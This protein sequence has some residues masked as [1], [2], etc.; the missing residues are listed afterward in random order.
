MEGTWRDLK[1]EKLRKLWKCHFLQRN[2]LIVNKMEGH[3]IYPWSYRGI[4]LWQD[5]FVRDRRKNKGTEIFWIWTSAINSCL[6]MLHILNQIPFESE[7]SFT[8]GKTANVKRKCKK[9]HL[10]I[11]TN[12]LV[13]GKQ[14]F[15]TWKNIFRFIQIIERT[16]LSESV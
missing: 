8:K 9:S 13:F 14:K 7:I 16:I 15:D 12:T 11:Y 1:V 5:T 2:I 10:H 6:C 3:G 4:V